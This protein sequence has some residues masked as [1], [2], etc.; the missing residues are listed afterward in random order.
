MHRF[1]R[2]RIAAR[3][4]PVLNY[5]EV[6]ANHGDGPH[7][8]QLA[9]RLV[10]RRSTAGVKSMASWREIERVRKDV[11][12]ARAIAARLL[13]HFLNALTA[14]ETEFLESLLRREGLAELTTRQGE[15]LLEIRDGVEPIDE[16]RGFSIAL[17]IKNV[18]E[19]RADLEEADEE[20]I[21]RTRQR[22]DSWI[23]RKDVGR[24]M[25]CARALHLVEE[26]LA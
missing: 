11:R 8:P 21:V 13:K 26:E 7:Y 5:R 9:H 22:G 1:H 24:L 16:F 14:W 2:G 19:A 3:R 18:H 15:K 17:L 4:R 20:W 23:R 25:A 12:G 6:G 10:P